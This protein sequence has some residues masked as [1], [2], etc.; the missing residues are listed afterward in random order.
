MQGII[1]IIKIIRGRRKSAC[2]RPSR[3]EDLFRKELVKR[4]SNGKEAVRTFLR[5][6]Q[7]GLKRLFEDIG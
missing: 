1:V 6:F 2:G 4:D 7:A 3:E 5:G